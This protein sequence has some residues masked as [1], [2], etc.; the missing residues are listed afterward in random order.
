MQATNIE[1]LTAHARAHHAAVFYKPNLD[2]ADPPKEYPI[3]HRVSDPC[4]PSKGEEDER[5]NQG[6]DRAGINSRPEL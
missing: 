4:E 2:W 5:K 1:C 3:G 6:N